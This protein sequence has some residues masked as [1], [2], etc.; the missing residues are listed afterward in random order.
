MIRVLQILPTLNSC[1]GVE[2]YVFNYYKNINK[3]KIQFDFIIHGVPEANNFINEVQEMGGKVYFFPAFSLFNLKKI[4][5]QFS[6]LLENEKY[7]IIHCHQAN[8][9]FL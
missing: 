9:A 8:A 7:S 4:K 5:S 1:G 3:E 2:N 6:S